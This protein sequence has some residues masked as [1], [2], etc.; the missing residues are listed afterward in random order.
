MVG[1]VVGGY[2]FGSFVLCVSLVYDSLQ[3]MMS[4][5]RKRFFSMFGIA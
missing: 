2:L 3:V 5:L 1:D 4:S